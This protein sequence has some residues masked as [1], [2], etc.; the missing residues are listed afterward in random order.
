MGMTFYQ[1]AEFESPIGRYRVTRG[2]PTEAM[3]IAD[4]IEPVEGEFWSDYETW[5][6]DSSEWP[7]IKIYSDLCC[8][9]DS[10]A[11]YRLNYRDENGNGDPACIAHMRQYQSTYDLVRHI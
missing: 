6:A 7:H 3:L 10:P 9:C 1:S 5:E 11:F 2:Y 8:W 4:K